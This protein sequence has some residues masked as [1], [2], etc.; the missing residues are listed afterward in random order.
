MSCCLNA[1]GW[2]GTYIRRRETGRKQPHSQGQA[3]LA[4]TKGK[5]EMH[6]I[7]R[8]WKAGGKFSLQECGK[9]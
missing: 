9:Q 8:K 4:M 1:Q 6:A 2:I 7:C 5:S 3:G